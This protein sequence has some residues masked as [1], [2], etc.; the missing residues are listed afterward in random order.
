MDSALVSSHM[1]NHLNV[2]VRYHR[3]GMKA[4]VPK[5]VAIMGA[6]F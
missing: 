3:I 2:Y 1:Y 5:L 6:H 4:L